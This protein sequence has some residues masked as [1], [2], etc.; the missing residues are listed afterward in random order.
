MDKKTK[1]EPKKVVKKNTKDVHVDHKKATAKKVDN[2]KA[3]KSQKISVDT[4]KPTVVGHGHLVS[5]DYVGTLSSGEEFDNSK[6]HGPIQ[7]VVGSNQV[8]KGF[9]AAVL[10]MKVNDAKKFTISKTDAYGDINPELIQVVPLEKIPEH[11]RTQLKVGGFLVMQSPVG[12]QMPVKVIKLDAKNVHLDMNHPL[13][14]KDLTFNITL[15][16]LENA[17]EHGGEDC[18]GGGC[19]D[20]SCGDDCCDDSEEK[21]ED[22]DSCGCGHKHS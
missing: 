20:G 21:S 11:I 6:Q 12:Q 9:D 7:F 5:V 19:G 16:G 18:C 15:V 13:A 8:I 4:P 22:C 10:G 3:T 2:K 14:G 17:P 1:K